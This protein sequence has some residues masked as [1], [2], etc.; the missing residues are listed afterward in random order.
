MDFPLLLFNLPLHFLDHD[1]QFFLTFLFGFRV[2]V[3]G[4][5]FAVGADWGVFSLLEVVVDLV[6]ATGAGL[7][8][9]GLIGLEAALVRGGGSLL[10]LGIGASFLPIWWSIFTAACFCIVSV[11]WEYR[12]LMLPK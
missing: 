7:A 3:P 9:H 10:L 5:P 8:V 4:N 12:C 1:C 2:H 11:T 6:D